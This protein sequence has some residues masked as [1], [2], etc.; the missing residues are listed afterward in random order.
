MNMTDM[1]LQ[2]T[3]Q[4]NWQL[5]QLSQSGQ[6]AA[7]QDQQGTSFQD[8]LEQRREDLTQTG[9]TEADNSQP[10]DKEVPVAGT[11]PDQ[12][13]QTPNL[14]AVAA[15]VAPMAM[16]NIVIPAEQEAA[17]L[18]WKLLCWMRPRRC[19]CLLDSRSR[20]SRLRW[21]RREYRRCPSLSSPCKLTDQCRR[22]SL[23]PMRSLRRKCLRFLTIRRIPH[24]KT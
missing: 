19:L 2:M 8:L 13:Q 3:L 9:K 16:P 21:R 23:L 14:E 1:L 5:P 11:E 15:A 10:E 17:A 7:A 20:R 12:E 22:S 24:R 4:A 6:T 18:L